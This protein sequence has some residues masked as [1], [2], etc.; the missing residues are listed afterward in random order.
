MNLWT[1]LGKRNIAF[2][3]ITCLKIICRISTHTIDFLRDYDD[4]TSFQRKSGS[5][6][7]KLFSKK[8][9]ARTEPCVNLHKSSFN[10]LFLFV[11]NSILF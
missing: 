9:G 8:E 7:G 3:N 6:K 5:W 2:S 10:L 11:L 4:F 1:F